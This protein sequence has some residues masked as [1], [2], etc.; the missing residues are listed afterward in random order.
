[1]DEVY[2]LQLKLA[3]M[4][5]RNR[6]QEIV[7]EHRL[8]YNYSL[9]RARVLPNSHVIADEFIEE[10]KELLNKIIKEIEEERR[11]KR[12]QQSK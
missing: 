11:Q 8:L 9:A 3:N 7:K 12:E 1:M 10:V 5:G 6:Y 4:V 2:Q